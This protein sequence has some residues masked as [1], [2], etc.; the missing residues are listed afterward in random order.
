MKIEPVDERDIRWEDH[1]A[2][3]RVYVFDEL[4][5]RGEPDGSLSQG[6]ANGTWDV[7]EAD[8]LDALRWAQ[9]R[10]GERGLYSIALVADGYEAQQDRGLVWLVGEHYQDTPLDDRSRHVQERMRGRRGRSIVGLD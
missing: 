5:H 8:L 7:T 2:R 4:G 6:N 9:E 3:F 1:Y 10:A